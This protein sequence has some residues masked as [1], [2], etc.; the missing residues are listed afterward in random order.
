[1]WKKG[2]ARAGGL[3]LAGDNVGIPTLNVPLV[4]D[5]KLGSDLFVTACS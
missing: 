3:D 2:V 1:M 5:S 4:D